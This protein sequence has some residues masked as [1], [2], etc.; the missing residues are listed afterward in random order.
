[1]GDKINVEI[2]IKEFEILEDV[3]SEIEESRVYE[4]DDKVALDSLKE[5]FS[6]SKYTKLR[7]SQ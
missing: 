7:D 1:M 4:G 2:T 6:Y 3:L 5:K